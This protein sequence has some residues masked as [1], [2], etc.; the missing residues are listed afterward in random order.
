MTKPVRLQLSRA[1]GFNLQAASRARNAL[2]ARKVDRSTLFG[3]PTNCSRP[4]NCAKAPCICCGLAEFCCVDSFREWVMSGL[5]QRPSTGG[6]LNIGLDA[7]AGNPRRDRL[8]R[9]LM[10]L[11]GL[12]LACWCPLDLPCHADVLLEL[13]NK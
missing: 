6:T 13:A 8:V 11:R 3:N 9:H 4:H 10:D 2:P 1:K 12:N 5:E 7:V